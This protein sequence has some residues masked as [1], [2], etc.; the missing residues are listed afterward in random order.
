[1]TPSP[2]I[3]PGP[4]WWEAS[5]LT[6]APSLLVMMYTRPVCC[7]AS[8]VKDVWNYDLNNHKKMVNFCFQL[9]SEL[10]MVCKVLKHSTE[11]FIGIPN[12]FRTWFKILRCADSFFNPLLRVWKSNETHFLVFD[13]LLPLKF[14]PTCVCVWPLFNP[15]NGIYPS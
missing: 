3:E 14:N 2:G 12:T 9:L 11:C 1:M 8:D 4:H 5:T 6:T 10:L 15:Q 13:V 7:F